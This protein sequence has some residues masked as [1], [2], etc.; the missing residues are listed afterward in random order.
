MSIT[1]SDIAKKAAVSTSTV[2]RVLNSKP[3]V[4]QDH[5]QR[6][7]AA[8]AEL[9]YRPNLL[10]RG[11]RT[12]P[13]E[14]QTGQIAVMLINCPDHIAHTAYM[15]QYIHGVQQA[16]DAAGRK[17]IFVTWNEESGDGTI[18]QVLLDGEIDGVI[19]K[20]RPSSEIGKQWLNRY[21]K[22]I[23]N[24]PSTSPDSDCVMVDY[25]SG[26]HDCVAY[27]A[28]L[29][30]R[31]IA[32]VDLPSF[33]T[34]LLGYRRAVD[35]L[36]LDADE[37]LIQTRDIPFEDTSQELDFS[38]AIENLWSL[39]EPPTAI[40]SND[41]FCSAI[42][43]ALAERGLKVPDDVSVIGY[44]NDTSYCEALRP[45]LTSVDIEAVELGKLAVKQLLD[46]IQKPK[47]SY[48]KISTRGKIVE[49]ESVRRL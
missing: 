3:D 6:V 45:K 7:L 15:M 13:T 28:S 21:P 33:H 17:C 29:G 25:E 37:G 44:D 22:I 8:M 32:F 31:R 19:I 11:L 34:K 9:D 36:G 42:Y 26:T 35:E 40:I 20:K 24:P 5:K 27:L 12:N 2:S 23:L 14:R 47:E 1:I 16:I 18:P 43:H 38:W 30:H 4:G 46:R 39:S 41:Y 48:R 10:A 49:R